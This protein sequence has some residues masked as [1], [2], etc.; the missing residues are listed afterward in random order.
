M[1]TLRTVSWLSS[2]RARNVF[3][4]ALLVGL[5]AFIAWVDW[6]EIHTIQ[7]TQSRI[8]ANQRL[9]TEV[10]RLQ[11]D[12]MQSN[13]QEWE[14]KV[15]KANLRLIQNFSHLT[16][17]TQT[18]QEKGK[19][20]HLGTQYRILDTQHIPSPQEGIRLVPLEMIV[21]GEGPGSSYRAFLKLLKFV[22]EAGPRVDLDT[23]TI[24]GNGKHATHLKIG[25]SVWM[26]T[27]ESVKL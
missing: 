8:Q 1:N 4:G 11:S 10:Q 7:D 24:T 26:K 19:A 2:P 25:L 9:Q 23:V 22:T 27:I 12:Y 3:S 17:W 21:T 20:L 13:P 16:Q 6:E 18:I 14:G 15:Q 5:L